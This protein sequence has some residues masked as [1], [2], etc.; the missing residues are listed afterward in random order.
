MHMLF[1]MMFAFILV[2]MY[3]AIRRQLASP[4][5]IAGA[6]IFGSIISMTFFGLA[7][8][9]L[10]AH[11]LI[12]GFIVGGGFSVATLIIAYYFQG[13]ELRRMAEHRVTDTRQPHL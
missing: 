11:A 3:I 4:T 7:Q 8:N 13:N 12:V 5:L 10:F 6:G 9:T 2:A 1:F